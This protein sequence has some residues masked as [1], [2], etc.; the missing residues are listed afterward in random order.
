VPLAR[1]RT[2]S[3]SS[4]D[5]EESPC[6]REVDD[7]WL[8]RASILHHARCWLGPQHLHQQDQTQPGSPSRPPARGRRAARLRRN[9]TA[10]RAAAPPRSSTG[11]TRAEERAT[12]HKSL[13]GHATNST[14][15]PASTLLDLH[16]K[17]IGIRRFPTLPPPERPPEVRNRTDRRRRGGRSRGVQ[18]SLT[19]HCRRGKGKRSGLSEL[20]MYTR[21]HCVYPGN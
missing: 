10:Q 20:R 19:F 21:S 9:A 11:A 12:A 4:L 5:W 17:H 3:T 2:S 6:G 13:S 18:K 1:R 7:P 16:Y 14:A 8:R 15:P